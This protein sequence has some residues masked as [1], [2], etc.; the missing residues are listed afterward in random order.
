M[1]VRVDRAPVAIVAG[2]INIFVNDMAQLGNVLSE[3][4]QQPKRGAASGRAQPGLSETALAA[5]QGLQ[6]ASLAYPEHRVRGLRGAAWLGRTQL[7]ARLTKLAQQLNVAYSML[8]HLPAAELT[9]MADEVVAAF[10]A[11]AG[12]NPAGT[13]PFEQDPMSL[14]HSSTHPAQLYLDRRRAEEAEIWPIPQQVGPTIRK[15]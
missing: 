9:K 2:G 14:A 15:C 1:A 13:Q 7:P 10:E 4:Q 11:L 12:Q 8:R 3:L 5:Q 6:A